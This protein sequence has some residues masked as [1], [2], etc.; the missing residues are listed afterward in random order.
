VN[1]HSRIE[2]I[3]GEEN[4]TRA[5]RLS[6]ELPTTNPMTI[7]GIEKNQLITQSLIKNP[8]T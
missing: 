1:N 6:I 5:F 3:N 7:A 4:S 2:T 8:N